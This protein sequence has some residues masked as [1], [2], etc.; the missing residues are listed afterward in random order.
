MPLSTPY[1]LLADL[2]LGLHAA[3]VAFVVGGLMLI[4]TGNLRRW[5]WVNAAWFRLLHLGAVLMVVAETWLDYSCPLTTLEMWLRARAQAPTYSGSFLGH[6]LQRL[7]YYDLPAWV[8]VG[9]Y[10]LFGLLV[11]VAWIRF[12]PRSILE[13]RSIALAPPL[14]PVERLLRQCQLPT[15]DLSP[16]LLQDFLHSGPAAEPTGVV[17]LELFGPI[18][19]LRSLAVAA[20][21][22]HG[23]L[24]RALVAAAEARARARG[25]EEICLLTQTAQPFFERL[26][27]VPA[28]RDTAPACIRT[29]SQFTTLCPDSAVFMHKRLG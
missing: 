27:Y 17:G 3:S 5:R 20:D 9:A 29:T 24:G 13:R 25:V 28:A 22:R 10:S 26:G 11:I 4:V 19:L 1:P 16:A 18:A 15:G 12:P 21:Q 8:F 2:V 23:G 14:Q 7:I 6:W